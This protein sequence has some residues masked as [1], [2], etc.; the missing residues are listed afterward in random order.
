MIIDHTNICSKRFFILIIRPINVHLV[1]TLY[2]IWIGQ[3]QNHPHTRPSAF[4][5]WSVNSHETAQSSTHS[6]EGPLSD[7]WTTNNNTDRCR[8]LFHTP[9]NR[10]TT[11]TT[12]KTYCATWWAHDQPFG[13]ARMI[14]LYIA[15]MHMWICVCVCVYIVLHRSSITAITKSV[16]AVFAP[17]LDFGGSVRLVYTH[18]DYW[19]AVESP[20][21]QIAQRNL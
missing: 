2:Q 5:K 3:P 20:M 18:T 14:Q 17:R 8:S 19:R 7:L 1:G 11:T 15:I 21:D 9:Y 10:P 16:L 13:K 4:H 12:T 6:P